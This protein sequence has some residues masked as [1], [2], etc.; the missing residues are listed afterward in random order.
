MD[1][2]GV[3]YSFYSDE[4]SDF[5]IGSST[6]PKTIQQRHRQRARAFKMSPLCCKMREIGVEKWKVEIIEVNVPYSQLLYRQQYYLDTLS[7]LLNNRKAVIMMDYDYYGNK[8][9]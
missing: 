2:T 1:I 3:V 4:C 8:K 7:P 5:Y 6:S 9:E